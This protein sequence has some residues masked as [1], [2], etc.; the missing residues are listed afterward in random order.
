MVQTVDKMDPVK[1]IRPSIVLIIVR[2]ED[3][4]VCVEKGLK[5]KIVRKV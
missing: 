2:A 3:I 5:G 1:E 4:N